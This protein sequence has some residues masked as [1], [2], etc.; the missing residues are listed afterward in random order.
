MEKNKRF[1]LFIFIMLFSLFQKGLK[2][3]S[4]S[5]CSLGLLSWLRFNRLQNDGFFPVFHR[6]QCSVVYS[7]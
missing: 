6:F 5:A 3:Y 7:I 1:Q 4:N 2:I